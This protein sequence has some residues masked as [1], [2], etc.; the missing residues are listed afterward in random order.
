MTALRIITLA[1]GVAAVALSGAPALAQQTIKMTAFAGHPVVFPWVKLMDEYFI[2]EVDKRLD[3]IGTPA[4]TALKGKAGLANARLAYELF[5]KTFAEPRA[6]ELTA[7]SARQ[8]EIV[9]EV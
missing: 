3:A 9:I 8:V 6:V 5:E 2:P 7:P 4:A 1:A